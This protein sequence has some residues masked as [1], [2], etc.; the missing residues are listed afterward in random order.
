MVNLITGESRYTSRHLYS[1][2]I[3]TLP[4]RQFKKALRKSKESSYIK[5]L[6]ES[7]TKP[8]SKD[9]IQFLQRY[10]KAYPTT[11]Y[12]VKIKLL[13]DR[14]TNKEEINV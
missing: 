4:E 12:A 6:T 11:S 13:L 7:D 1:W 2:G 14:I 5:L 3:G 8:Q 10:L 9:D